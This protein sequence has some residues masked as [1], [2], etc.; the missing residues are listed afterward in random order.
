M[1]KSYRVENSDYET[2]SQKQITLLNLKRINTSQKKS[3][4][5]GDNM[6]ENTLPSYDMSTTR[7]MVF[8]TPRYETNALEFLKSEANKG[9]KAKKSTKQS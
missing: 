8:K 4:K 5:P 9:F 3:F 6:K 2:A 1:I 7:G